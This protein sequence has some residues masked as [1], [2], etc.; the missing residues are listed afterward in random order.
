M[1]GTKNSQIE[2]D[3]VTLILTSMKPHETNEIMQHSNI[4]WIY[5]TAIQGTIQLSAKSQRQK[6]IAG[7]ATVPDR[8]KMLRPKS[9]FK[10][11]LR[12]DKEDDS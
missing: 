3:T 9:N 7:R 8:Q 11:S 12:K 10:G 5:Q 6:R 4:Q 1:G 2:N